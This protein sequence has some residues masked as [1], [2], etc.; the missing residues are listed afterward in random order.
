MNSGMAKI[1]M[2]II[3]V[4]LA[5]DFLLLPA[6]LVMIDRESEAERVAEPMAQQA[7]A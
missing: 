7:V 2:L 4:A 3:T 1:T 5:L 6:L